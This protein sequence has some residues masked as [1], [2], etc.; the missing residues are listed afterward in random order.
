VGKANSY[1]V[2]VSLNLFLSPSIREY[3][4]RSSQASR[5]PLRNPRKS[6]VRLD[7]LR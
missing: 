1:D 2:D 6:A 5:H 3:M 4:E 7:R